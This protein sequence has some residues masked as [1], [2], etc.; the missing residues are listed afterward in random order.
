MASRRW[1]RTIRANEEAVARTS[2]CTR[3]SPVMTS[4]ARSARFAQLAQAVAYPRVD[5]LW[6]TRRASPLV[7]ITGT[8]RRPDRESLG[9]TGRSRQRP[10]AAPRYRSA[11]GP[12]GCM[13]APPASTRPDNARG[14]RISADRNPDRSV[15]C[16]PRIH[17]A[18][19][20]MRTLEPRPQSRAVSVLCHQRAFPVRIL[21]AE[22]GFG[23]APVVGVATQ[24]VS[25][26]LSESGLSVRRTTASAPQFEEQTDAIRTARDEP[27][28]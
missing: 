27:E 11:E 23:M 14:D 6:R 28:H 16:L 8:D 3:L 9:T 15:H 25:S 5:Y 17:S 26:P 1:H 7:P 10:S 24:F 21:C 13:R 4:R 20:R 18:T 2:V 19:C 12:P 22:F